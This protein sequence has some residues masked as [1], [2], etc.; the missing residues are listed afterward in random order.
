[1]NRGCVCQVRWA[2]RAIEALAVAIPDVQAR[3]RATANHELTSEN[4][5]ETVQFLGQVQL[6]TR[7]FNCHTV[8]DEL[9]ELKE[10]EEEEEKQQRSK[11]CFSTL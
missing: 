6:N 2:Q 4:W 3:R 11:I 5:S 10:E 9:K 8:L 7:L 1:M